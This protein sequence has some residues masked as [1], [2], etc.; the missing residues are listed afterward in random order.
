MDLEEYIRGLA[1]ELQEK[2]RACGSVEDLIAFAK[3]AGVP[4]PDEML[5]GVAGGQGD[6]G[7]NGLW[8]Y[9]CPECGAL[10]DP[11][12]TEFLD[13]NLVRNYYLCSCGERYCVDSGR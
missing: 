4:L 7:A 6:A 10:N 1:P 13:N 8:V 11:F 12:K 2:A 9:P 3:E 5:M